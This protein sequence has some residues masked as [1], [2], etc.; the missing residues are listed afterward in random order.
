MSRG[1]RIAAGVVVGYVAMGALV[2]ASTGVAWLILGAEA[3]FRTGSQVAS[4]P[5]SALMCLFGFAAA[6]VGGCLAAAV[7]RQETRT[8]EQVLAGLVLAL[9]FASAL[10]Q[11]GAE[12][13][14]LPA[15]QTTAQLTWSEAGRAAVSPT[16]Y[17]FSIPCIGAAGVL[18]GPALGA[19]WRRKPS[20]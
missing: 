20:T 11:L 9:G 17:N 8:P 15:G 16:W 12:P 4:A 13:P 1:L 10:M 7:G 14:P 3:A 6:A 2:L 18:L 5:W 19:R